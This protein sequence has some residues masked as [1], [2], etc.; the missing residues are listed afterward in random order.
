MAYMAPG[1]WKNQGTVSMQLGCLPS[2][3]HMRLPSVFR[4]DILCGYPP[5]CGFQA[6]ANETRAKM[7]E[8]R[9]MGSVRRPVATTTT[10]KRRSVSRKQAQVHR[11]LES[12]RICKTL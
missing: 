11:Q 7:D 4:L 6:K 1:L 10:A 3:V 12:Q 2:L 5:V 8:T 9:L